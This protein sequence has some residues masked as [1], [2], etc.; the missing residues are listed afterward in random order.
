MKEAFLGD[1]A[2]LRAPQ[3]DKILSL[4]EANL[5]AKG[6]DSKLCWRLPRTPPTSIC[7]LSA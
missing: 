1:N 6:N 5:K 3:D 4:E 7:T 2:D